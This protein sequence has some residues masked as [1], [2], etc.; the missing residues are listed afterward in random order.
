MPGMSTGLGRRIR[1]RA[2]ELGFDGVGVSPARRSDRAG[3]L[4]AW[5]EE[6]FHAE[7][8]YMERAPAQRADPSLRDEWARS[9]VSLSMNYSPATGSWEKLPG[10]TRHL[11]RYAAGDD[12]HDVMVGRLRGLLDFMKAESPG[13]R[14]RI[15]VDSSPL[16]EKPFAESAGLGWLGRNTML[17]GQEAG[18]WTFLG[19][20]VLDVDLECDVP[21]EDLC[22]DCR[23]C[24][25]ACPTGAILEGRLLDARRC[26]SYLTIELRGAVPVEMRAAMGGHLFG[27]DVCQDVCP[28]NR[29]APAAS[30]GRFLPR[31]NYASLGLGSV[32]RL[33]EEGFR[34]AFAG[35]PLLRARRSGIVR[36]ALIAGANRGDADVLAAAGEALCDADPVIRATAAWALGR[37]RPPG[38]VRQLEAALAGEPDSDV[39]SEI[40][41]A[42]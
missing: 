6:G 7:M 12:Y 35:S 2:L 9:V 31:R 8:A 37:G 38:A 14:G 26:I 19:E 28:W 1:T 40:R 23:A 22:G 18:S 21:G 20:V 17:I 27:C 36:N 32:A 13:I 3:A 4:M 10:L 29:K 25:E 41:A 24:V 11:S 39:A 34:R 42:L 33:S 16:L 15:A 5:L 30:E